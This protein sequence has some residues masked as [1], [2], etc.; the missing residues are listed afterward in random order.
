MTWLGSPIILGSLAVILLFF[1]I[2][3]QSR[4]LKFR[5]DV[6]RLKT[7]FTNYRRDIAVKRRVGT[8]VLLPGGAG[9]GADKSVGG[10]AGG[11]AAA[12]ARKLEIVAASQ[13]DA[14]P[15]TAARPM[16]RLASAGAD[17]QNLMAW[18]A[19]VVGLLAARHQ[20]LQR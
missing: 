19:D 9:G 3:L 20:Q 16:S 15:Q 4:V 2:V 12:C 6:H 14:P 11:S 13:W 5:R 8:G 7:D 1:L 18:P 17:M 10:S